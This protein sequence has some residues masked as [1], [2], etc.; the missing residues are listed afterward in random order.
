MFLEAVYIP[1]KLNTMTDKQNH[2]EI[3]HLPKN[4]SVYSENTEMWTYLGPRRTDFFGN[5]L[6]IDWR[7]IH[8]PVLIHLPIFLILKSVQNL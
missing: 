6:K 1:G 2:L 5:T 7:K 8:V 4:F 3:L